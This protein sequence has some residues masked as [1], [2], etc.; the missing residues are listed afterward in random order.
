M[1]RRGGGTGGEGSN[2]ERRLKQLRQQRLLAYHVPVPFH[3][4]LSL[5]LSLSLT[6]TSPDIVQVEKFMPLLHLYSRAADKASPLGRSHTVHRL[7]TV[8]GP[9]LHLPN[10]FSTYTTSACI[11]LSKIS[12]VVDELQSTMLRHSQRTG[13]STS[14][15]VFST[16]HVSTHAHTEEHA[17]RPARGGPGR[18]RGRRDFP[19]RG[20]HTFQQ[21]TTRVTQPGPPCCWR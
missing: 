13:C 8:S 11:T 7:Y 19:C 6:H 3:L 15:Q 2:G 20:S 21:H 9:Q 10:L 12:H 17:S 18:G 4:P 1:G 5:S 16:P 14:P